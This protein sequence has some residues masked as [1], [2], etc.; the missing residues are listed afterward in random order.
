VLA[1]RKGRGSPPGV[2]RRGGWK[3]SKGEGNGTGAGG[4]GFAEKKGNLSICGKVSLSTGEERGGVP[5]RVQAGEFVG[6]L[7]ES[8]RGGG[9]GGIHLKGKKGSSSRRVFVQRCEEKGGKE[10]GG[11]AIWRRGEDVAEGEVPATKRKR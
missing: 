8:C 1:G 4:K 11:E 9:G 3:A 7:F 6:C 2:N 10:G 5:P